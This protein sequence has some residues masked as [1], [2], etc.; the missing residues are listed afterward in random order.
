MHHSPSANRPAQLAGPMHPPQTRR[1]HPHRP[2]AHRDVPRADAAPSPAVSVSKSTAVDYVTSWVLRLSR[3]GHIGSSLH[4][5]MAAR[6]LCARGGRAAHGRMHAARVACVR[7]WCR[8]RS[9]ALTPTMA[10]VVRH[11]RAAHSVFI[12]LHVHV[13][14]LLLLGI[15]QPA[16][17]EAR[18][19]GLG[20][21]PPLVRVD[22]TVQSGTLCVHALL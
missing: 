11:T 6:G 9:V 16:P 21:L 8:C 5:C 3:D 7:A 14:L 4:A 18:D 10:A 13:G 15:N 19:N 1:P 22:C 2:P 12:A 20:R 17:S